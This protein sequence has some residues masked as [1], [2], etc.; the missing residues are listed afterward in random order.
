MAIE[1]ENYRTGALVD[2]VLPYVEPST[3]ETDVS[4]RTETTRRIGAYLYLEAL[5]QG[6]W[7]LPRT[8][9]EREDLGVRLGELLNRIRDNAERQGI[10]MLEV[11]A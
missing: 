9:G 2:L 1:V 10:S 5:A 4:Y 3:I 11:L 7:N 8:E 6:D